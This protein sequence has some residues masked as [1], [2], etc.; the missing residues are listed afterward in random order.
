MTQ[1]LLALAKVY[2]VL[3]NIRDVS[4]HFLKSGDELEKKRSFSFLD[5]NGAHKNKACTKACFFT[6]L[7]TVGSVHRG[8]SSSHTLSADAAAGAPVKKGALLLK[9]F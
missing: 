5:K 9:L 2:S 3:I 7:S 6:T 1:K 4:W 8:H